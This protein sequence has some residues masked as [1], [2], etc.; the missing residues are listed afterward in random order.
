MCKVY[1][2]WCVDPTLIQLS[3]CGSRLPSCPRRCS[4]RSMHRATNSSGNGSGGR[5]SYS[6]GCVS[7]EEV[8]LQDGTTAKVAAP[9]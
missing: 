5:R 4:V 8:P 6:W 7:K 2:K 9:A 1:K 3:P